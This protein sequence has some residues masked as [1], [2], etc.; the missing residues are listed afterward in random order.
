MATDKVEPLATVVEKVWG[1]PEHHQLYTRAYFNWVHVLY[2][3]DP[4][5]GKFDQS[6]FDQ[7]YAS[8]S[9][10]QTTSLQL[11]REW[12]DGAIQDKKLSLNITKNILST[13]MAPLMDD[14]DLAGADS[15]L[16]EHFNRIARDECLSFDPEVEESSYHEAL[17]L[18]WK[19]EF[20]VR[21]NLRDD[22]LRS[23]RRWA[24]IAACNQRIAWSAF[25]DVLA[26]SPSL[27]LSAAQ[28][29]RNLT[30]STRATL[31][32]CPW[33][34]LKDKKAKIG[35]TE[36]LPHYLWDIKG[37]RTIE[38]STLTGEGARPRY[39]T[40]S[41]TW[42]RWRCET[43]PPVAINGVLWPVPL[44]S[45][46]DVRELPNILRDK[47]CFTTP[48]VWIDLFCIPQDPADSELLRIKDSEI[49]RQGE[50]FSNAGGAVIWFNDVADWS[51]LET[52]VLWFAA[53]F[54][55][56]SKSRS[57]GGTSA[58]DP[59]VQRLEDEAKKRATGFFE[60]YEY[61]DWK[62]LNSATPAGWFSSLWTLQEACL[63]P[64]LLLVDRNWRLFTVGPKNLV[65]TLD[66]LIALIAGHEL[67]NEEMRAAELTVQEMVDIPP[68]GLVLG[69]PDARLQEFLRK[70][71]TLPAA[72]ALK[73]SELPRAA[74]E[75]RSI[76]H[77]F[78]MT[79]MLDT[80][81]L[82]ILALANQRYC[83]H[84]RAQAIMSV[85]GM[86]KWYDLYLEKH[87][88]AP[89]ENDLVLGVF[90]FEFIKE[91][92][93]R[94][95]VQFF[96]SS[97]SRCEVCP[98]EI[99][100]PR[101][102]GATTKIRPIGSMLPFSLAGSQSKAINTS[103]YTETAKG[104]PS[105]VTWNVLQDGTVQITQAVIFSSF[106][107]DFPDFQIPQTRLSP[108]Q[109]R[110]LAHS[111]EEGLLSKD[112][113]LSDFLREYSPRFNVYA[114]LLSHGP[115]SRAFSGILLQEIVVPQGYNHPHV[116]ER[117]SAIRGYAAPTKVLVRVGTWIL[118]DV[119]SASED[120]IPPVRD[121][122]WRVL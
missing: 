91:V 61:K 23:A 10:A 79:Q 71:D 113:V 40:I 74:A 1:I 48:Y 39:L 101:K 47:A 84:S 41:H 13:A 25:E 106:R 109:A 20:C 27:S 2:I 26:G 70:T 8:M 105:V 94:L 87:G 99:F 63:R 73:V 93:D 108:L 95:G 89:P 35:P 72:E 29:Q 68:E 9:E 53:T 92:K 24:S 69:N 30:F 67:H 31:S 119:Q 120:D 62:S 86:T 32:V 22:N 76:L 11:L 82:T 75:L 28:P 49:S 64:D 117:L 90:P 19:G 12:W 88:T 83:E 43:E 110:V 102:D 3:V 42:G 60:E 116:Q 121:V 80:R 118:W 5:Q 112:V 111:C 16:K 46:F 122:D 58:L 38:V 54:L 6:K 100:Q 37:Q 115:W 65:L 21:Q 17:F 77:T 59:W 15:R 85:L 36:G 103:V 107:P 66:N 104:H 78:E 96:R 4:R 33:L 44:N 114:V 50:I 52:A 45:R 97:A 98:G 51:G 14:V 34:E 81:P 57:K 55:K 56:Q 7:L 18:L